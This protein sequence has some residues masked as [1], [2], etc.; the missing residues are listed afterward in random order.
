MARTS[1][2]TAAKNSPKAQATTPQP[3]VQ[4]PDQSG[5]IIT[6]RLCADP[7]L[8]YTTSG[9][10]VSTLR[11]AVNDGPEARFHTV[12]VWGRTAEAVCQYL[13][14]GRLVEVQGRSQERTWQDRNGAQRTAAEISAF[15]VRFL[16]NRAS[17]APVAERAS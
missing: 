13:G 3:T 1:T 9:K 16:P 11:V 14:K 6:G 4:T 12:V 2:S 8:R 15:R 17:E 7:A 10:S 5:V